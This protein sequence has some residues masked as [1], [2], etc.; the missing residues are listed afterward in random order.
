MG[1]QRRN[2]S[3][4]HILK[5]I[6]CL[7]SFQLRD[8]DDETNGLYPPSPAE[9][10]EEDDDADESDVDLED[11][12]ENSDAGEDDTSDSSADELDNIWADEQWNEFVAGINGNN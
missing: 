4:F 5:K 1:K 2:C 9:E 10:D 6:I 3:P 7:L 8:V 11:S 12:T